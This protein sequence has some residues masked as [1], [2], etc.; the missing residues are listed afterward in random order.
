MLARTDLKTGPGIPLVFLHGFLGTS[1]D[2]EPLCSHLP[3]RACIGFDLPGHGGSPFSETFDIPLELFHLVGYSLGGRLALRYAFENP[4]KVASLTLLSAH[5]GLASE[6]EK[7]NRLAHDA[8]W[9]RLLL[10]LPLEEFLS[11]WYAQP[12]FASYKPDLSQRKQQNAPELAASLLHYSLG[13]QPSYDA[14]HARIL[15]GERDEKFRKL[16]PNAHIIPNA[17]HMIHLENPSAC[18]S[19]LIETLPRA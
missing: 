7:Q 9:A 16:H 18:A 11:R 14:S 5:P 3:P 17:G 6:T 10:S 13:R 8:E 12:L 15:V 2:W 4:R 19:A 1:L